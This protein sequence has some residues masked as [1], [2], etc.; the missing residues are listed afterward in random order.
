[1]ED[2]AKIETLKTTTVSNGNGFLRFCVISYGLYALLMLMES[3][4]FAALL[5]SPPK[6]I[7]A[8]YDA[9][10][11]LFYIIDFAACTGF[12]LFLMMLLVSHWRNFMTVGIL[13]LL[14]TALRSYMIY[15]LYIYT[16]SD[17]FIPFI[18]KK[19]NLLS[20]VYRFVFLFLQVFSGVLCG[21]KFLGKRSRV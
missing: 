1:M 17:H 15:Y 5:H 2:T 16:D 21:W 8:T 7:H 18:Y 20:G 6:G 14:L 12:A 13:V 19:A 3:V 10:H 11:V 9:S 4:D